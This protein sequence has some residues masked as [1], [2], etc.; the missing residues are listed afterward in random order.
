MKLLIVLS[1]VALSACSTIAPQKQEF[2]LH[3]SDS[4]DRC[5]TSEVVCYLTKGS[6]QCWPKPGPSQ[7]PAPAPKAK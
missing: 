2:C 3:L 5:E 7:V 1:V 6:Q 4:F